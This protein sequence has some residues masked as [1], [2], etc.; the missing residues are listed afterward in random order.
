MPWEKQFDIDVALEKAGETFW[1]H[2]YEATSI[3]DL[4]SAMGIQKGSFYD[5]YGSKKEAYLMALDQYM[6]TRF[7]QF[8]ETVEQVAP[9]RSL[10]MHLNEIFQECIGADGHRGCMVVNCAL[11]L[12]HS[13][14]DAQKAVRRAFKIHEK[15]FLERIVAAQEAGEVSS[16]IDAPATAKAIFAIVLGMRVHSRAGASKATLR[17]LTDQALALLHP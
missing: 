14:K 15:F 17:T 1:S 5:T 11:E 4:L 7:A 9:K 10:E 13:D 6:V 3:R 16:E 12:A 2:G 8:R